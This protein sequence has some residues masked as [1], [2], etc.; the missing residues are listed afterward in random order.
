MINGLWILLGSLLFYATTTATSPPQQYGT[1]SGYVYD[2]LSGEPLVSAT[3]LLEEL[4]KGK[5]TNADGY[6]ILPQ[7]PFGTYHLRISYLGYRHRTI[8]VTLSAK[9]P[10][11]SLRIFLIPDTIE[12]GK[13]VVE[14]ER[15]IEKREVIISR[16]HIPT[17]Q[18]TSVRIASERD[19][20]RTLQYLPGILASSQV[21]SG[22]YIRGGSPDQNLILLDGATV[23]NPSHA[24]GFYSTFN[25]DAIKDVQL[26]KGGFPAEY[27][28]R[29]SAVIDITQ[30]EG[31]KSEYHGKLIVGM[32]SSQGSVEGPLPL[33]PNTSFFLAGRRTYLEIVKPFLP[34]DPENPIPDFYFYDLNG[35]I[36]YMPA[37]GNKISLGGFLTRDVFRV[38]NPGVQFSF[39]ILNR[40]AS[41][42]WA[43]VFNPSL[44]LTTIASHSYYENQ[45]NGSNFGFD[46]EIKNYIQDL[47][48]KAVAEY[49]PTAKLT[50]KAGGEYHA[51]QFLYY[52]NFTGKKDTI[53]EEGSGRFGS[54]H[55]DVSD[56]TLSTFLQASYR[57]SDLLLLQ[58]GVRSLT[59]DLRRLTV[60]MPRFAIRYQF[61]PEF[62][63][64]FLWGV[65]KQYFYLAYQPNFSFFDTW[66]PTD[67][68]TDPPTAQHFI[69][70]IE[71][72][73]TDEIKT[74]IDLYY[75]PMKH[76][77]EFNRFSISGQSTRD[78]FLF[79]DGT[80]YGVELFVQKKTGRLTGWIGYAY[81]YVSWQIDS[82]NNG[83]PFNPRYDRRHDFKVVV[84]YQLSSRW[85]CSASFF[86]QSGQPYTGV[87]SRFQS[88][89]PGEN[90]GRG[91]TIPARLYGL[92]L[93]PSHQLNLSV[94]YHT[95]IFDL[96]T[97]VSL[98]IYN[99][100]S[101]RDIFA[102]I[103]DTSTEVTTVTDVKLLPIVPSLSIEVQL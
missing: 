45:L 4:R 64:K 83:E 15:E 81:G 36:T 1:I 90:P 82:L 44:L 31:N 24:F 53:I 95:A 69:L 73:P 18:L 77:A 35:K 7:V 70:S 57:I 49:Y 40:V 54:I 75:K 99:V 59:M 66:L 37:D 23:Y 48:F 30:K 103:Y 41:L 28:D 100:Y 76:I 16:V 2:S 46:F 88:R 85:D 96:P 71:G 5:F 97:I 14:A 89:F 72:Y 22:L 6:F 20:F 47:A 27:G 50:L 84:N 65:Y 3:V 61:H 101:R 9:R 98:D 87:T 79:G 55:F 10:N 67:P 34:E 19:I 68:L 38:Q 52:Q 58:A 60:L 12:I 94:R 78:I 11:R 91:V 8:L 43:H 86:F 32:L 42:R 21:S 13:V 92:R 80:A 51:Y 74:S 26:Y 33:L 17:Q 39:G 62:A 93:P 63:L 56:F 25:A 29:M 102:R